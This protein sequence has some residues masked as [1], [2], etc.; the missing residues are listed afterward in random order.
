[1]RTFYA[2]V[3]CL[4]ASQLTGC[5]LL[6]GLESNSRFMVTADELDPCLVSPAALSGSLAE[7]NQAAAAVAPSGPPW[8]APRGARGAVGVQGTCNSTLALALDKL[9]TNDPKGYVGLVLDDSERKCARFVDGLVLAENST[10]TGLDVMTTVFSALATAFTPVNTIHA[11]TA[12]ASISGGT[13]TAIDSDIYAK[14]SIAIYAQA[15]QGTYYTDIKKYSDALTSMVPADIEP[16]IEVGKIQTIHE[17]CNLASAQAAI[18]ATLQPSGQTV[19]TVS[20]ATATIKKVPPAATPINLIATS[21]ALK[22][23]DGGKVEVDYTLTLPETPANTTVAKVAEDLA[24]AVSQ[25]QLLQGTGI[26]ASYTNATITLTS[27]T[28]LGVVWT[29][30]TDAYVDVT[31]TTQTGASPNPTTAPQGRTTSALPGSGV[32]QH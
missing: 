28:S 15:I 17:E 10:N 32:Q 1:V 23:G 4:L 6:Q 18:S 16:S 9:R 14:A 27:P 5:F 30:T 12:A 21:P 31:T 22:N 26:T 11:L 24:T 7:M 2:F 19:G 8:P 25:K 29:T 20:T 13:K 3:A